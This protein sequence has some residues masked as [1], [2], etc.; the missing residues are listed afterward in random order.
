[1]SGV[2]VIWLKSFVV[3]IAQSRYC[4]LDTTNDFNQ[5]TFTQDTMISIDGGSH[6]KE[7]RQIDPSFQNLGENMK[8]YLVAYNDG[9]L[10]FLAMAK[11]DLGQLI[12]NP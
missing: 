4:A 3:L 12:P 5:I 9:N 6:Y 10:S 11:I 8:Y 7:I 2:K 1:M